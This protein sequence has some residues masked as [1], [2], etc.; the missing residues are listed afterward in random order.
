MDREVGARGEEEEQ[1]EGAEELREEEEEEEA[2]L[3]REEKE[4]EAAAARRLEEARREC[5]QARMALGSHRSLLARKRQQE[6]DLVAAIR[7]ARLAYEPL[8]D[9]DD[10]W[11]EIGQLR[12]DQI[13]LREGITR[14][15]GEFEALRGIVEGP[16]QRR[17]RRQ[18]PD[19]AVDSDG[20]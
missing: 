19:P 8:E 1:R 17:G 15:R 12:R 16:R 13:A 6:K 10:K 20:Y 5:D 14:L 2:A 9:E 7:E 4:A 18:E 3:R 11:H